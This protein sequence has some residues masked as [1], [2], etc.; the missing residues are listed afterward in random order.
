M[1]PQPRHFW[2]LPNALTVLRIGVIPIL[3]FLMTFP[4]R[5]ASFVAAA[6][7]L[8]AGMTDLLDGFFARRQSLT[9]CW[10]PPPSLCSF[11]W[12]GSRPGWS[13]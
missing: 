13:S 9:N 2:N 4:G 3:I 1:D 7:F 11:P 12:D 6:A 8:A 5:F 10:S